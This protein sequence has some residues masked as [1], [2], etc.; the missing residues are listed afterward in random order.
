MVAHE[1]AHIRHRDTLLMSIAATL[2]GAIG[3][4]AQFGGL[5]GRGRDNRNPL[6]FIGAILLMVL[7]PIAA[8]VVQ[9]AISRAREYE[10]D[11]G[12]AE[13]SGNPEWLASAL[14]RLE[15][16]K[17]RAVNEAAEANPATAHMFIINPL[18]G[19]GLRGLFTTHPSTEERVARL[20]AMQ[21]TGG[22]TLEGAMPPVFSPQ[23]FSPQAASTRAASPWLAGKTTRNPWA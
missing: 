3:M 11:R 12:G 9:M 16:Y 5:F 2:S 8:A 14:T 13:I 17:A 23:A 20:R 6:G 22:M 21:P 7:G 15:S 10:A 19:A 1:L 18:S 4:L